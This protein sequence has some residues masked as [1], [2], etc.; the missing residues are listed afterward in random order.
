MM[1]CLYCGTPN[2][3][4]AAVCKAC[5]AAV[6]SVDFEV[7]RQALPSG[8]RLQR[9]AFAVGKILGQGGFAITYMGSDAR[10]GRLVAI[11]EFFPEGCIRQSVVVYPSARADD[12][13]NRRR[14]F[15]EEA[16]VL[17]RFRHPGIVDVHTT[18]EENNTAYMVMGY[19]GRRSLATLLEERGALEE[20][21]AVEYI[22]QAGEALSVVHEAGLLHRDIKPANIM[23]A[24]DGRVVLIDFG[25]A[26]EFAPGKT[27]QMT[28]MVTRGY[29][30]LEQYGQQARF[31]AATDIYALGATLY[32][33]LTGQMPTS[34][35][36]RVYDISLPTPRQL[37]PGLS[38][39]VND[40]VTWALEKRLDKRPQSV[41]EFL[42]AL[43][44]GKPGRTTTSR[45]HSSGRTPRPTPLHANPHL[46]QIQQLAAELKQPQPPLPATQY[47]EPIRR[48]TD[49][50]QRV[51]HFQVGAANECPSC[52]QPTFREVTGQRTAKCPLCNTTDLIRR[53]LE[54]LSKCPVCRAGMLRQH[55]PAPGTRVCPVCRAGLLQWE[56]RG[57][58]MRSEFWWTCQR[59]QAAFHVKQ[60]LG[61]LMGG[62]AQLVSFGPDPY[63][64]GAES[65]GRVIPIREWKSLV[66]PSSPLWSCATCYAQFSDAANDR[67]T[68]LSA[69]ADPYGVVEQYIGISLFRSAWAKISVGLPPT[70]GNSNCPGCMAEFQL[71]D[72]AKT[73]TLVSP[74][75]VG[76][77]PPPSWHRQPVPVQRW[78]L[79]A[80]GKRSLRPG[81]LCSSCQ[82]EF[83]AVEPGSSML[84]LSPGGS[85]GASVPNG[86]RCTLEDWRRR[87]ARL[88]TV[89]DELLMRDELKGLMAFRQK[90]LDALTKP[91]IARRQ[92]LEA[93][94]ARVLRQS[95]LDGY[96]PV[97]VDNWPVPLRDSETLRWSGQAVRYKRRSSYGR[98]SWGSDSG[99]TLIVTTERL[100]LVSGHANPWQLP[101]HKLSK[102]E[103][104]TGA[105]TSLLTIGV[106]WL[107][108]PIVISVG[109]VRL[110]GYFD[111]QQY[112]LT[113]TAQDLMA[114]LKRWC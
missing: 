35:T 100:F 14:A 105:A 61:G 31:G 27:R 55:Q 76:N 64:I 82:L 1:D 108:N 57:R 95:W 78:Y 114:L 6:C 88:P 22:R 42:K 17:A 93:E 67:L 51:A 103:L 23:L 10:L 29:A 97:P 74:P 26:R 5:G 54:G 32:H 98:T 84:T 62:T 65:S 59:C 3:A 75:R 111:G 63:G 25:T 45:E 36:D 81:W 90:D 80:A 83:D 11:K 40:A 18:F 9:G 19:L 49:A 50:L 110:D 52:R 15:L 109:P 60:I 4:D 2:Q 73:F 71:D 46:A 72:E 39:A 104:G 47:D 12:F 113:L 28:A 53:D 102:I 8:F 68:L 101:L 112:I 38:R 79:R 30:P 56:S 13:T 99:C 37:N 34:A 107:Q 91:W 21:E 85:H 66:V 33:L 86:D 41:E 48:M 70:A 24:D 94:F 7:D 89:A 87:F 20:A 96:V 43:R 106:D 69:T 44:S 16:R 77:S 92:Q 58:W